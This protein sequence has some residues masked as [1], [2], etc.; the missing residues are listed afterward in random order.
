MVLPSQGTEGAETLLAFLH[1]V[2]RRP[3]GSKLEADFVWI[4]LRVFYSCLLQTMTDL[5]LLDTEFWRAIPLTDWT[6]GGE[7][8]RARSRP[9]AV[10]QP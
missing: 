6:G 8:L 2:C 3:L 10:M 5:Q 4:V 9:I 7:K 1:E